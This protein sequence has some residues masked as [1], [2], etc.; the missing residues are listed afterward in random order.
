MARIG[1]PRSLFYYYYFPLWKTFFSAMGHQVVLSAQTNRRIIEDGVRAAVDEVCFPVKTYFGHVASLNKS[2][3]YIFCPRIISIEPKGYICPKFMG[4]PD[5][6]AA[7]TISKG[8]KLL[9]PLINVKKGI[10]EYKRSMIGM[11]KVLGNSKQQANYAWATAIQTQQD[12]ESLLKKELCPNEA[13]ATTFKEQQ[14]IK[15]LDL[16][17]IAIMGHGYNLYDPYLSMNLIKKVRERGFNVVTP[18][19][20]PPKIIESRS[21]ELR[22]RVFWTLGKRIMGSLLYYIDENIK[23]IIYIASFGCGPDSMVGHIA[24]CYTRQR[25]LPFIMLTIDE[26]TGEAGINTRIEAFL[27]MLQRRSAV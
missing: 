23:G 2:V 9:T 7:T 5:M 3:D 6:I 20:A 26:H 22:K 16:P 10:F 19:M 1:I 4:L 15:R 13:I 11:A 8:T 21:K 12:F 17:K 27:D 25:V 18:E 14:P 24:E